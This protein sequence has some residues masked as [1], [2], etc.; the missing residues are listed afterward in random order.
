MCVVSISNV[1]KYSAN[2][3]GEL[4]FVHKPCLHRDHYSIHPGIKGLF[5]PM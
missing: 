5:I 4:R 3:Q 2:R 1:E